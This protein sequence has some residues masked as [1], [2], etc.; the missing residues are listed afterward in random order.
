MP[1]KM[2]PKLLMNQ[3]M[4]SLRTLVNGSTAPLG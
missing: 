2:K 4:A 3:F 1:R